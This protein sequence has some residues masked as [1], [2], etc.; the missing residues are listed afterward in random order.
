MTPTPDSSVGT[1]YGTV[2]C[3]AS[4]SAIDAELPTIRRL[5]GTPSDLEL[6]LTDADDTRTAS[7]NTPD[8][9]RT[10]QADGRNYVIKTAYPGASNGA[11]AAETAYLLNQAYQSTLY[12]PNDTFNGAIA[13]KTGNDYVSRQ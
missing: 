6:S 4:K 13:Y 5:V 9:V 8:I 10:A 11:A 2:Y 7:D 3:P 1:A 12:N